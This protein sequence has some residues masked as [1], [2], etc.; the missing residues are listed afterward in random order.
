MYI[1]LCECMYVNICICVKV[2]FQQILNWREDQQ[3]VLH[4]KVHPLCYSGVTNTC[5]YRR[6]ANT[7]LAFTWKPQFSNVARPHLA[8]LF[9]LMNSC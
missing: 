7:D 2:R 1:C 4:H 5:F 8:F 3:A 9:S 6:C